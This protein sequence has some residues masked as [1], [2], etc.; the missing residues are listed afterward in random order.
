MSRKVWVQR[1][2]PLEMKYRKK[3]PRMR[4]FTFH[5]EGKFI[6]E[7]GIEGEQEFM[8]MLFDR[9]GAGDFQILAWKKYPVFI[10]DAE[11]KK[12]LSKDKFFP[13]FKL[14]V[15]MIDENGNGRFI[16]NRMRKM[17]SIRDESYK[18][19]FKGEKIGWKYG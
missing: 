7:D 8:K 1:I 9:F 16:Y 10:R 6:I 11:T 15:V 17:F 13:F 14:A 19:L 12:K 5:P 3:Y 2:E 4:K 18:E